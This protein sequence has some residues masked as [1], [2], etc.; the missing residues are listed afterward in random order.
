MTDKK[1]EITTV[2]VGIKSFITAI[3]VIFI[4]MILNTELFYTQALVSFSL[5]L[6]GAQIYGHKSRIGKRLTVFILL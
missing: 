1:K 5:S 3:I 6:G 2:D 4:M